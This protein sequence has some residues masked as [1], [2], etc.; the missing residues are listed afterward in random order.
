MKTI[1]YSVEDDLSETV[2][3]KIFSGKYCLHCVGS[4]TGYTK[5]KQKILDYQNI[6]AKQNEI[7][8]VLTDLDRYSCPNELIKDWFCDRK[9]K[10]DKFCFIVSIKTIESWLL[11]DMKRFVEF[12]KIIEDPKYYRS[13]YD[14]IESPRSF[15]LELIKKSKTRR[16]FEDILPIDEFATKGPLYNELLG[17]FVSECWRLEE[18]QKNSR[19]LKYAVDRI[20][21]ALDCKN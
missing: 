3:K 15:I 13:N 21:I 12:F 2:L 5:I 17:K 4:K 11:A 18:A 16:R 1:Y 20:T 14:D 6:S 7:C 10:H 9:V 19:S 8:I